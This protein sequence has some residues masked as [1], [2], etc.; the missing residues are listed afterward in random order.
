MIYCYIFLKKY[1]KKDIN[2]NEIQK[3]KEFE[4]KNQVRY[5]DN[6]ESDFN[7]I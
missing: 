5:K 6:K 7:T 3:I 1:D 2:N 4:T